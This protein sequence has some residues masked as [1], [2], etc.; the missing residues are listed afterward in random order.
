MTAY[1][2]VREGEAAPAGPPAPPANGEVC[3]PGGDGEGTFV[4]RATRQGATRQGELVLVEMLTVGGEAAA[5]VD[6]AILRAMRDV[7]DAAL[8]HTFARTY[9]KP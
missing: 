5:L 8:G 3:A 4:F 1:A 2:K 6:D 9:V 7:L